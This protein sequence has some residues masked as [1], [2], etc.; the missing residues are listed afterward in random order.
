MSRGTVENNL[1]KSMKTQGKVEHAHAYQ[2]REH[3]FHRQEQC[4]FMPE[5]G[6]IEC[7]KIFSNSSI[8]QL[9]NI[10]WTPDLTFNSDT[11]H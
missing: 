10:Y 4:E 7:I 8:K 1:L 6:N 3:Q 9:N 11:Q 2:A 5:E